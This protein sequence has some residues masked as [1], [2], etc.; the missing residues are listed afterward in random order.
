MFGVTRV[1]R[2][3]ER[4]VMF[5]LG[6]PLDPPRGPG[7]VWV[8]P[9]VDQLVL[10]DLRPMTIDVPPLDVVTKDGAPVSVSLRVRAQ[11]VEPTEAVMRVV[12][13]KEATSMLAETALRAILKDRSQHEALHERGQ[14]ESALR[15]TIAE[16]AAS[17]GV[18]VSAVEL[19][20]P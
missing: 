12:D 20:L 10:V 6:K 19:S 17:W 14:L 1:V 16:A 7:R 5:R 13:W 4:G 18:N 3:H 9:G 2:E 8:I 11:V 15:E